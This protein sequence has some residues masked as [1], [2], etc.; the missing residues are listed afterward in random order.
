MFFPTYLASTSFL[1]RYR[2]HINSHL[3]N[4]YYLL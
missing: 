3:F 2:S 4:A 1:C